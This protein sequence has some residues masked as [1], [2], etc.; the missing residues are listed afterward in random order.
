MNVT[1]KKLVVV[2]HPTSTYEVHLEMGD[3]PERHI[4]G[5]S[6][7]EERLRTELGQHGCTENQISEAIDNLGGDSHSHQILVE[8]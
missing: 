1:S 4:G 5:Q 3:P 6:L 7:N 2:K 8:H